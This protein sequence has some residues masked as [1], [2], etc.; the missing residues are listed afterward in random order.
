[1]YEIDEQQ[2][3]LWWKI[4]KGDGKLVE[5][6]LLGKTTYSGYFTDIDTLITQLKPLLDY[7]N[8]RYYGDLQA[9]FTLN[10]INPALYSREQ[11]DRF[12]KKPKSTTADG[13]IT[14][15][16]FVLI[17]LD[18][19]RP[20]G[21]S[22]SNEEFEKAHLK[23][24]AIYRYLMKQGFSEPIITKSGNGWHCYVACDMPNDEQH[25]EL[26]K[27][28]LESLS[29][30]FSD[31]DI[32]IDE[33]VF[34]P[35]RIDKLV[36]TWAKKGANSEER[37]WRQS[38][39]AK[40]PKEI[41]VNGDDLFQKIAD[42]LPKEEPK[43]VQTR[44]YGNRGMQAPFD[45]VGWLNQHGIKYREGASNA[46]S[47]KF[48]LEYCP[49]VD[50]HTDH[51]KWDSALFL[52]PDGKITFNCTHSHCKGRTWHDFRLFYEP[53][54]YTRQQQPYQ[55]PPMRY[56]QQKPQYQIK[57]E[58][59]EL[60]EKWMSM[61]SIKKIDLSAI[62]KVKTGFWELDKAIV[63]LAM[64]EVTLLSGSNSSGKSSWLNTL[65]LNIIDQHYK[66]ALWSGEL[67]AD[68]LKAW[69]QMVAA[70]KQYLRP[71]SYGDGKYYVPD[72]IGQRIDRW[73]D[74]KFY[75][76]NNDYGTQAEQILS[77]M[78]LLVKAG[79]KVFMLD[80]LFS[81]NIDLLEGGDKNGRQKSLILQLKDFAKKHSCHIILVAHPRKVITFL[82]KNDI[83]GTSDLTN[84]VDNVFIIH[85]CNNDFYK[86]GGEYL[87]QGEINKFRGY[88]NVI[89]VAKNRM[90]GIVDTFVG[91]QYEIE[92][93][94][95]LNELNEDKHYGWEQIPAEGMIPLSQAEAM[96]PKADSY[97][98]RQQS[99]Q[100]T[101]TETDP[102]G[103][104]VDDSD[105]PF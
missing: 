18:P 78:E 42:L 31:K 81:M 63:G 66:V 44:Q 12:V 14:H 82:R 69:I 104:P 25:N 96:P 4:F 40:I 39:F 41:A 93:R 86:A 89:E 70:G 53:D 91:M 37:P 16:S 75:L 87:G 49:W 6:R 43:A 64:S 62:E 103:L 74:G 80:N 32:E 11:K 7:N 77:D 99:Q 19:N 68:I 28:F 2:I 23:A 34:N 52:D 22:S 84:A 72:N 100:Q 59:P 1:M 61:S 71:S 97:V 47:R 5:V 30:Q 24:V 92:S 15:R 98:A 21:I 101:T 33:K 58:I 105:C 29:K 3:R 27:R 45:L 57:D 35:A 83:S 76:Y 94:R 9:Y 50:Q 90:Y 13:D 102:L 65:M 17:D 55:Q 85:R 36:G 73:L 48:E 10:D 54:A 79:V 95:F 67:R 51:K 20:A 26:V 38:V 46:G 56:Y 8:E 88:G 60:G